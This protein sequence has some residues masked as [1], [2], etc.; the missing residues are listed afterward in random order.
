MKHVQI[1]KRLAH[2]LVY[3]LG[4]NPWDLD[5]MPGVRYYLVCDEEIEITD[6]SEARMRPYI[7][8]K[9]LA[10]AAHLPW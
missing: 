8:E 4:M 5:I 6:V 10:R 1:S 9:I 3:D 2:H 7:L